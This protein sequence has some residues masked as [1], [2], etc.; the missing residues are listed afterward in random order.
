VGKD[1]IEP[2]DIDEEIEIED[3]AIDLE[4]DFEDDGLEIDDDTVVDDDEESDVG[5]TVVRK[6]G[7]DD[8]E[9]E[10]MLAPDDVEADLDTI[11]KDRLAS[12]NAAAE[13]DD[14]I[15]PEDKSGGDDALQ[16]K[17]PDEVLCSSCFL[18]VRKGAPTCPVGDDSCPVFAR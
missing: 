16:P 6:A 2:E 15:E 1:D 13:D 17:R 3:E 7:E 14:E 10:D 12:E 8:D 9:D 4:E 18:L 11:L 5:A